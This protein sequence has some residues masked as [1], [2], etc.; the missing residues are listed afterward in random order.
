MSARHPDPKRSQHAASA[1]RVRPTNAFLEFTRDEVEQSVPERFEKQ[2]LLYADRPAVKTAT[3]ELTYRRLNQAANRVARAVLARRGEGEEPVAVL[4]QKDAPLIAAILGVL[5]AGK[6]YVPLDGSYPR[7]RL[8]YM[9]ADSQA[10]LIVTD[11]RNR[12]LAETLTRGTRE[13]IQV[14]EV[15]SRGSS[16]NPGLSIPPD[17]L[18]YMLYTSGSTGQ[19]KGIVHTHRGLL[20]MVLR[21]TNSAHICSEDRMSLLAPVGFSTAVMD[22][23]GALLNGATLYPFDLR[24]Q[25]MTRVARC[26]IRE[27]ITLYQ[28]VPTVFRHFVAGLTGR[29]QFPNLRLIK[30]GGEPLFTT[31]VDLHRKHFPAHALFLNAFGSAEFNA[32][33]QY[34]VDEQTEIRAG[35][36]PVGY[37]ADDTDILLLDDSG[38]EV[39]FGRIGEIAIRSRYL[40]PGYWNRPDLTA[41]AFVPDP[42]GGDLLVYRTGDLGRMRPVEDREGEGC[43]EW[44]GRKDFQVKVAGQRVEVGEVETALLSHAAIREAAVGASRDSYGDSRLVAYLVLEQGAPPA[45]TELRRFLRARLP[46]YMIPSAFVTLEAMPLTPNG[47][48]DRRALPAPDGARPLLDVPYVPPRTPLEQSLATICAEVLGLDRVGA[49]DSFFELGGHSLLAMRLISRVREQFGVELSVPGFFQAPSVAGMAA[50]ITQIQPEQ[51][52]G[53]ALDDLVDEVA[54]LSEQEV[55]AMLAGE[56][57]PAPARVTSTREMRGKDILSEHRAPDTQRSPDAPAEITSLGILTCDRPEA[58]R[59]AL[60]GYIQN[61]KRSGRTTDFVVVD[62]SAAAET[63][64]A[65]RQMLRSLSARYGATILYAGLEEKT[66]YARRLIDAGL[67]PEVVNFALFDVEQCGYSSGANHNALMLH[68]TGEALF[69]TDDDTVCWVAPHPNVQDGL[70]LVSSVDPADMWVF[71]D[72]ETALRSAAVV[73]RDILAGHEQLL[74]KGLPRLART[75]GEPAD[76]DFERISPGLRRRLRSPHGRVRVTLNGYIG[77]CGWNAPFGCWYAPLGYLLLEGPSH[78]RLVRSEPDYRA[79]CASR[80]ILRVVRRATLSD[81]TYFASGYMG[82]DNRVLLPPF[83]PVQRGQGILFAVT[84]WNCF[85]HAYFGHLPWVL[86]H[87][88]VEHRRFWPGEILRTASGFDTLGLMLACIES[89]P[90]PG[91]AGQASSAGATSSQSLRALGRHLIEMGSAPLADFEALVRDQ[92][93][94]KGR[95]FVALF[96][97]RLRLSRGSPAFW[98]NDV[99]KYLDILRQTQASEAPRVPLELAHGRSLDQ[100]RA[101]AQRLALRFGQLVYWWPEMVAAA[102]DLRAQGHRLARP[103]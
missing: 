65:C 57:P 48:V 47:K 2:V 101:L 42:Q 12:A 27:G 85:D 100:A 14:D 98:A 75:L 64:D 77:D 40:S 102:R 31:D 86:L 93:R 53:R 10:G 30:L 45:L 6:M 72:R 34:F 67:S 4:L 29:E 83:M 16:A 74:G 46:D 24:D 32:A 41:A 54:R 26:L 17:A 51:A 62:D 55:E 95:E 20:H 11:T 71:P 28:S 97:S 33:C 82:L 35:A 76:S 15:D 43:L 44:L 49:R 66:R 60:A 18:A 80:E 92:V 21:H 96:E 94:R 58:L 23:F 56:A 3:H 81:A 5:K 25:G 1:R 59:R 103:V 7:A 91:I 63:R 90:S 8:D 39:G 88:P 70:A 78:E 73:E 52:G 68:T 50:A 9:L 99:R 13:L 19:P 22:T 37:A 87:A 79:A 36:L 84:L 38:K 61:I 89:C 69:S